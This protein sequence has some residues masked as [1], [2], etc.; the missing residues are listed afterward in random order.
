[1]LSLNF[2]IIFHGWD[3]ESLHNYMNPKCLPEAYGGSVSLPRISGIEW[4][5]LLA[6]CD[7]EY[8]GKLPQNGPYLS[9]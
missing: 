1:M 2:Q 9:T 6:K 8:E 7:K 5:D 3:R 4:Y